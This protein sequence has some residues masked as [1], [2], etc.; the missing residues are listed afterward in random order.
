MTVDEIIDSCTQSSAEDW[1]FWVYLCGHE[2]GTNR[3]QNE[4]VAGERDVE[5]CARA[6]YL[7]QNAIGLSW[8]PASDHE[9][10]SLALLDPG[11]GGEERMYHWV[12][13]LYEGAVVDRCLAVWVDDLHA[14]LPVPRAAGADVDRP[15]TL[16]IDRKTLNLVRLANEVD[17]DCGDFDGCFAD[18]GIEVQ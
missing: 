13:L 17:P 8:S 18:L 12:E 2:G 10:A 1:A 3:P 16:S 5:S 11:M 4:A 14:S 9:I 6:V 15:A 7:K